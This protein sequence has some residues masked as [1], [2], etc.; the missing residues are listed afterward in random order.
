RAISIRNLD[1]IT[2][3]TPEARGKLRFR[4][5]P[6]PSTQPSAG[7]AAATPG[8]AGSNQGD[9]GEDRE[10]GVPGASGLGRHAVVRTGARLL[11]HPADVVDIR[12]TGLAVIVPRPVGGTARLERELGVLQ[13][14]EGGLV[15]LGV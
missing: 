8:Q 14:E 3:R 5:S 9:P 7:D 4:S 13:H 11:L 15:E 6:G 2:T 1:L 10:V 12:V